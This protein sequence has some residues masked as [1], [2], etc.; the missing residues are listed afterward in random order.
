MPSLT[1]V[2]RRIAPKRPVLRKLTREG[3]RSA[4]FRLRVSHSVRGLRSG[5]R[6]G[7]PQRLTSLNI[8]NVRESGA[9]VQ[10]LSALPVIASSPPPRPRVRR[11]G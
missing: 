3:G 1:P 4:Y 6:G 8:L 9:C 10:V 2:H 7:P 5:D 11:A